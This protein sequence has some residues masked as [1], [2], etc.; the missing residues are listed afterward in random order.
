MPCGSGDGV[1]SVEL[2]NIIARGEVNEGCNDSDELI[3]G[4]SHSKYG[5]KARTNKRAWGERIRYINNGRG[6]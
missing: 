6:M 1:D 5:K 3:T 2:L 4:R